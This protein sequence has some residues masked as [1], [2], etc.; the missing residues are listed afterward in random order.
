MH[1]AMSAAVALGR[2]AVKSTVPAGVVPAAA[3]TVAVILTDVPATCGDAG[4]GGA[5]VTVAAATAWLT[6]SVVVPEAAANA[7]SPE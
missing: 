2:A 3:T 4:V 7:E 1:P 5:R 6:V